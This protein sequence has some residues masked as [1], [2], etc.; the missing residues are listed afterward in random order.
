M[1]LRK[2]ADGGIPGNSNETSNTWQ[3]KSTWAKTKEV[4]QYIA[5]A[6]VFPWRVG[7]CGSS[8]E[9]IKEMNQKNRNE[10]RHWLVKRNVSFIA[11]TLL[12]GGS[13]AM[14]AVLI[15]SNDVKLVYR[16]GLLLP[17]TLGLTYMAAMSLA[18]AMAAARGIEKVREALPPVSVV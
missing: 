12:V 14:A 2:I 1:C 11:G 8:L 6:W 10:E 9:M 13:L 16:L 5:Q 7:D 3:Q 15:N 18:G 4:V 17:I